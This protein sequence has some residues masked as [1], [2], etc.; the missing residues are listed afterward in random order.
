[1]KQ[2]NLSIFVKC[3]LLTT[4]ASCELLREYLTAGP[5]IKQYTKIC[6]VSN[7]KLEIEKPPEAFNEAHIYDR[8]LCAYS[9][10]AILCGYIEL[11]VESLKILLGIPA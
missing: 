8:G 9:A 11:T 5:F 1:M 4:E 3:D 6:C 10:D 7:G 2:Q